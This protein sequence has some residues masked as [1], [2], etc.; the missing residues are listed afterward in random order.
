MRA[1]FVEFFQTKGH[2]QVPSHAMSDVLSAM[3]C[4]DVLLHDRRLPS[5]CAHAWQHPGYQ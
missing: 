5:M 3:P 1:A 2:T 4:G